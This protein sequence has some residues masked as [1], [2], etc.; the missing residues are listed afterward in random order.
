MLKY[1]AMLIRIISKKFW[2]ASQDCD[3]SPPPPPQAFKCVCCS[4]L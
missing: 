1:I 4:E 3:D 2:E